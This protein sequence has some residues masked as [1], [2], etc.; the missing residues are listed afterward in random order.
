MLVV[1]ATEIPALL[2]LTMVLSFFAE[3]VSFV[4]DPVR[5]V[6]RDTYVAFCHV[7]EDNS[8]YFEMDGISQGR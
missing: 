2:V 3:V 1:V 4:L 8:N 6:S 7:R 5:L